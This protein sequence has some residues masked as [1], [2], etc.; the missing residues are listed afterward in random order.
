MKRFADKVPQEDKEKILDLF[1]GRNTSRLHDAL[2]T[3]EI[4]KKLGRKYTSAEI[5]AVIYAD[6][7]KGEENE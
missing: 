1:Y 4:S 7:D 5:K 6:I 3:D 2:D